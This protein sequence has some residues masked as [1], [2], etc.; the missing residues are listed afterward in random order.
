M[1]CCWS[2]AETDEEEE[3][4]EMTNERKENHLFSREYK[5][6]TKSIYKS[7]AEAIMLQVFRKNI[8]LMK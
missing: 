5:S 7:K 1:G 2:L 3:K 6:K 4:K 8:A